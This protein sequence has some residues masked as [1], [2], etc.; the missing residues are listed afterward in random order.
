MYPWVS[1]MFAIEC[2]R[3]TGAR[4]HDG[5]AAKGPRCGE[6]RG[7][8]GSGSGGRIRTSDLW[9][10]SPTSCHC[11][12]PRRVC[13]CGIRR[14]GAPAAASPPTGSPPQYSPALR[15]VTTG[16]GMGPGGANALSATGTPHRP[17]H[18][19]GTTA[20]TTKKQLVPARPD[21]SPLTI[22]TTPLQSVARCPRV[23]YQPGR[24]PGVSRGSRPWGVSSWGGIPA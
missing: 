3:C 1:S 22:R 24:L 14:C 7:A 16:F 2:A 8:G 21:T 11:S 5:G 17:I 9:V 12:T 13:R 6:A 10:M 4:V 20:P 18:T 15:R 23:A 19:T